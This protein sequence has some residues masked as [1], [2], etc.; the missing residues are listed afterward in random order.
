MRAPK[1]RGDVTGLKLMAQAV[2]EFTG[3]R[4][5]EIK[6]I[7]SKARAGQQR[8]GLCHKAMGGDPL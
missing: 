5:K 4:T 3:G 6:F 8:R 2:K 7:E 1:C